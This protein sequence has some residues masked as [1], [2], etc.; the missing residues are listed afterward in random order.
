MSGSGLWGCFILLFL[1]FFKGIF[2]GFYNYLYTRDCVNTLV[3]A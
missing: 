2:E 1:C 3:L